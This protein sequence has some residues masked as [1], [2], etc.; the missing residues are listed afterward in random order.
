[1]AHQRKLIRKK[2]KDVLTAANTAAG[3]RV[4]ASRT[5]AWRP[6]DLPA[7]AVYTMSES[8]DPESAN[9]SP[10]Y[11]QRN[12]QI[13]VEA[14]VMGGT[15]DNQPVGT[16]DIDDKMDDLAE[17]IERAINADE[18][19]GGLLGDCILTQ[20]DVEMYE[21]NE[22]HI[23]VIRLTWSGR[24]EEQTPKPE[25]VELD[26][27]LQADIRYKLGDDQEEDDEANDNITLPGAGAP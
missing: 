23:G 14:A 24:Y 9:T 13:A 4:Y 7:I 8:V 18:T 25:D 26:D 3:V 21:E 20:T 5:V 15:G 11:L 6:R 12:V 27:F 1:M 16:T 19:L 2:F 10:R 22:K 17:E